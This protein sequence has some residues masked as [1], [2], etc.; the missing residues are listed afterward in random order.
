VATS[1]EG[2][3]SSLATRQIAALAEGALQ[4]AGVI[5]VVPTPLHAVAAAAG[6]T[7]IIDLHHLPN[8]F[9]S[10]KPPQWKRILGAIVFR[11]RLVF[12]DASQSESRTRL[13][14]AHEI[15]HRIIP[16]HETAFRLDAD[17]QLVGATRDQ[18]ECEAYLAGG[19]LVFQGHRFMRQAL[20]YKITIA[21]PLALSAEYHAS[22]HATLRYY[23]ENHPDPVALLI[24][25]RYFLSGE[26]LPVWRSVESPSFFGRFGALSKLAGDRL[27]VAAGQGRPVGDIAHSAMTQGAVATK[28][29][30]VRDLA[31]DFQP[32]VAEAF[33]NKHNLFIMFSASNVTRFGR[34]LRL[35]VA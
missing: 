1:L 21:T 9:A 17:A 6:I 20:D 14:E 32:F 15:G 19:K 22:R 24:T 31:G 5:G 26:D 25:G 12:V 23:V 7:D 10:Q 33:F 3:A 35:R 28:N 27:H 8:E 29:I 18:L 4:K 16:W 30:S 2:A 13:T 11:E 34:R